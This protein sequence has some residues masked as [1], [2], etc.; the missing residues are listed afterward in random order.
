MHSVSEVTLLMSCMSLTSPPWPVLVLQRISKEKEFWGI[1]EESVMG[2]LLVAVYMEPLAA[3]Q[4]REES[5]VGV[6]VVVEEGAVGVGVVVVMVLACV[7]VVGRLL[8]LVVGASLNREL[9]R[10]I[11]VRERWEAGHRSLPG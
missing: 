11:S 5:A 6:G 1:C 8:V 3:G 4:L 10:T 7:M 2:G 9:G